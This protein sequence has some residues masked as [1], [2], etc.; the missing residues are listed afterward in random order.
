MLER[1]LSFQ[2]TR[3]AA[4]Q[5]GDLLMDSFLGGHFCP[6]SNLHKTSGISR[7]SFCFSRAPFLFSPFTA[8]I[9]T[10]GKNPTEYLDAYSLCIF[11]FPQSLIDHMEVLGYH[12]ILSAFNKLSWEHGSYLLSSLTLTNERFCLVLVIGTDKIKFASY[13]ALIPGVNPLSKPGFSAPAPTLTLQRSRGWSL[14]K[15]PMSSFASVPYFL[16]V[17]CL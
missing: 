16:A 13:F 5:A 7:E 2:I 11:C 9:F 12:L 3:R 4:A 15:S 8:P 10:L 6:R 1:S 14:S 17:L